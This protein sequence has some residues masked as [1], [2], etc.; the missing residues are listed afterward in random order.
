MPLQ[1]KDKE[2]PCMVKDNE[3]NVSSTGKKLDLS[4]KCGDSLAYR[5]HTNSY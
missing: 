3:K 4:E 2:R 5:K 1:S